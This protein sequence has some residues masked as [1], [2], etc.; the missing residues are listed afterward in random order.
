MPVPPP[1]VVTT[2]RGYIDAVA[3]EYEA[4]QTNQVPWFRGEPEV[5][6]PLLPKVYREVHDENALLQFFRNARTDARPSHYS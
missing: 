6:K 2:V 4:W 3:A 5:E 1:T